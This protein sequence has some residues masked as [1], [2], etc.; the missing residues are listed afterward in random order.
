MHS[1][2]ARTI[3]DTQVEEERLA[4]ALAQIPDQV[5]AFNDHLESLARALEKAA[6]FERSQQACF[7]HGLALWRAA[8]QQ[9]QCNSTKDDRLLYWGRL[10]ML[11]RVRHHHFVF[12]LADEQRFALLAALEEASRGRTSANFTQSHSKRILVSGFDPFGFA[13]PAGAKGSTEGETPS[14]DLSTTN[15]SGAAALELSN[16]VFLHNGRLAEVQSAIFPVRYEDFDL[17]VVERFF[18]PYMEQRQVDM[19]IT[20]S[21]GRTEFD[22]ERYTGRRRSALRGD[23]AG[24]SI[25]DANPVS[26]IPLSGSAHLAGPEFL[27]STLPIATLLKLQGSYKVNDNRTITFLNEGQE[28]EKME[29]T[30]LADLAGR[31]AHAGS[32]GGFLSNEISYRTH[33]LR[34][35]LG[36]ALA[37]GHIHVPTP[38]TVPN[39]APNSAP[40]GTESSDAQTNQAMIVAQVV[41]LVKAALLSFE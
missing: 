39:P 38:G 8:T 1:T 35:Q 41:E 32:G 27:E 18:R 37:V 20:I 23:N 19:I 36:V 17:G 30:T 16:R 10:R 28:A 24:R 7:D 12:D 26:T 5:N 13:I 15:P 2:F 9:V 34:E 14:A 6:S 3:G 21:R 22:L 4:H 25:L 33:L 29:A 11:Q 40:N 31:I